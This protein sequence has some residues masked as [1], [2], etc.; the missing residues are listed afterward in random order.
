MRILAGSGGLFGAILGAMFMMFEKNFDTVLE[1]SG[2]IFT[3]K[4]PDLFRYIASGP[5]KTET[6]RKTK[7]V[8]R[9]SSAFLCFLLGFFL[10]FSYVCL[11]FPMVFPLWGPETVRF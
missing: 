8:I 5:K 1:V 11:V 6:A 4:F 7:R 2:D 9:N 3:D 10:S